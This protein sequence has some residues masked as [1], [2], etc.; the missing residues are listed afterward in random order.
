MILFIFLPL[1]CSDPLSEQE[2]EFTVK[3]LFNG[4]LAEGRYV[5]FWDGTDDNN[6]YVSGG[7]YYAR[8]YSRDFTFQITLTAQDGGTSVSNDSSLADPG[9]QPLPQ[10][11]QNVPNPFKIRNGT[12]LPFS[13]DAD[14]SIRLTIRNKE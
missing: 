4:P 11:D 8:L 9:Y 12:N 7:T 3:T 14:Y 2:E 13:I 6:K 5:F 10:L 1:G